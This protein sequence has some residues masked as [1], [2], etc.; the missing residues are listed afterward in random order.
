MACHACTARIP[1]IQ[2]MHKPQTGIFIP[3]TGSTD[4]D[5]G[6]YVTYYPDV[7][8]HGTCTHSREAAEALKKIMSNGGFDVIIKYLPVSIQQARAVLKALQ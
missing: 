1:R 5:A 4:N 6:C 3:C 7:P 2:G 8:E